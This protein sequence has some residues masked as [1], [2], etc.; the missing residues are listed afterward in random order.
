[1]PWVA[2]NEYGERFGQHTHLLLHAAPELDDLFRPMP[3]RWV[4]A[5]VPEKYVPCNARSSRQR[6]RPKTIQPRMKRS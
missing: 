6:A 4:K 3:L 5:I 2:V 1:M